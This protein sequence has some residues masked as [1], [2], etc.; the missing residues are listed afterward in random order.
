MELK[1]TESISLR[2]YV[3][4]GGFHAAN[5]SQLHVG[6][7]VRVAA[8]TI[9]RLG[10]QSGCIVR[11]ISRGLYTVRSDAGQLGTVARRDLALA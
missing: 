5:N 6:T 2:A 7:R 4:A 9:S 1:P 10:G 3:A 11:R 8:G